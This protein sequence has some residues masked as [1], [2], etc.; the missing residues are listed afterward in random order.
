MPDMLTDATPANSSSMTKVASL[1]ADWSVSAQASRSEAPQER[2]ATP[3]QVEEAEALHAS[4][5]AGSAAQIVV[6]I[7]AVIGLIYILKVIIITTLTAMLLAFV[8]EPLV[9]QLKRIYVPR[10]VGAL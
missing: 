6:A 7:V 10:S 5:K 3:T 9:N 8:L 2:V 4:I 1:P